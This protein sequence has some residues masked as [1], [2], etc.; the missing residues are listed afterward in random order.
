[1]KDRTGESKKGKTA[2]RKWQEV[3]FTEQKRRERNTSWKNSFPGP[4]T[5]RQEGDA[6]GKTQ[7][8]L[9]LDVTKTS[10]GDASSLEL[11]L[12]RPGRP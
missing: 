1:M 7:I 8:S 6:P 3:D 9:L 5:T 2:T 10:G 12:A 11:G 4:H